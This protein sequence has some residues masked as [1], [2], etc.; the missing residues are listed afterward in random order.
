MAWIEFG[1]TLNREF[2]EL[3]EDELLRLGALAISMQDAQDDGIFEPGDSTPL[4]E[5]VVIKGLYGEDKANLIDEFKTW[6]DANLPKDAHLNFTQEQILEED[7]IAA[8]KASFPPLQMAENFWVIPKWQEVQDASA[9]NLLI[10]PGL[11][12]G[13]GNHATTSLCLK[14][15]IQQNLSQKSVL[16][17][18]CGSG[19]LAIASLLLGANK[20]I[21]T[22]IDKLALDASLEN[23][24]LNNIDTNSSLQILPP[25][26]LG[27]LKVEFL[28]ANILARPL[29]TLAPIL[30]SYLQEGGKICLS[31]ILQR[32]AEEVMQAYAN[33][34]DWQQP[35]FDDGWACLSGA[36]M[37]NF[38][39]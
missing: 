9:I 24:G 26:E 1:L 22:D 7:W 31:G 16:D 25:K 28:V 35:I 37:A 32:Q 17:Y 14:W 4:W 6:V 23:A 29:I 33:W 5:Q 36:L 30:V 19:I 11:A 10:N 27:D 39:S 38:E 21:G 18:G 20:A 3:V 15:L 13:T 2:V 34:I 8:T 12:F